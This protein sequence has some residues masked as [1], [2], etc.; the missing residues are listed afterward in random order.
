MLDWTPV[1]EALASE[2][3][4]AM[5]DARGHGR[6][7][8]PE[9]GY[10][11]A[12]QGEDL[13][14]LITALGLR[15]PVVPGHS[16]GATTALALAGTHPDLPAAILLE[17]PPA[18][19]VGSRAGAAGERRAEEQRAGIRAWL[20]A[21]KRKTPDEL[22]AKQRA[23]IP[24]WAGAELGPWADAKLRL[25]GAVV[26]GFDGAVAGAVDWLAT[27]GRI[28]CPALLITGDPARGAIVSDG[29]ARERRAPVPRLRVAHIPGAGHNI[30]RDQFAGYMGAIRAALGEWA[31]A[32]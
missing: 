5:V 1:A 24:N 9:G 31:R 30:R 10:D 15:R 16:M 20:A 6:S 14:G 2:H 17:D 13:A 32:D 4:I 12:A 11:A 27:V 7:D 8:P 22:L 21:I 28:P 26:G 23:A 25:S 3:D 19:W 29:D 18:W